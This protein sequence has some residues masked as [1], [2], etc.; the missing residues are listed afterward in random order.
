MRATMLVLMGVVVMLI[1]RPFFR[2]F[3]ARKTEVAPPGILDVPVEHAPAHLMGGEARPAVEELPHPQAH[4]HGGGD[5][6]GPP[7]A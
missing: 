4:T 7:G 3:F 2:E 5:T 1:S 6:H